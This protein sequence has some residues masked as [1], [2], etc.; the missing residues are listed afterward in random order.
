MIDFV[1]TRKMRYVN[2]ENTILVG[3]NVAVIGL[4]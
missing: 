3:T 1:V 4:R 2:Y